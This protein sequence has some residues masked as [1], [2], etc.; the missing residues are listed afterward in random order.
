MAV[1]MRKQ[2]CTNF[3]PS[4]NNFGGNDNGQP[5]SS[6]PPSASARHLTCLTSVLNLLPKAVNSVLFQ[7]LRRILSVLENLGVPYALIGGLALAFYGVVRAT[8]DLDLLIVLS[9]A[10]VEKL[11][12]QLTANGLPASPRK[13]ASGDPV[14]GVVAAQVP[15]GA[16]QLICALLLPSA[17]WQSEAV[18]KAQ[19]FDLEGSQVRVVQARDLF[20]LKLH[21]GGPQDL[22][23]TS[24][25]LQMQDETTGRAWKDAASNMHMGDE[26][27]WCLSFMAEEV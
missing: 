6:H 26:L 22:L 25:L 19:T 5:P 24:Q 14:V 13:G 15:V 11:A 23:D 21:A 8:R 17:R 18:R 3:R 2:A 27:K 9:P 1:R 4:G 7:A 12:E 20:L 10:D 16:S